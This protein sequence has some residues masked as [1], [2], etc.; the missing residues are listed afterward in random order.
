[1]RSETALAKAAALVSEA[2]E[3]LGAFQMLVAR[4]DGVGGRRF[5]GAPAQQTASSVGDGAAVLLGGL[6]DRLTAAR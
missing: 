4:L 6:P 5:A 2:R 3:T 1:V